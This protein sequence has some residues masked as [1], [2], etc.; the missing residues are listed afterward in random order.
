MTVVPVV[1]PITVLVLTPKASTA[2]IF[3]LNNVN[4]PVDEDATVG[5]AP[6][7]LN[8]V[9]LESVTVWFKIDAVP[10]A[11]TPRLNVEAAPNAVTLVGSPKIVMVP[12]LPVIIDALGNAIVAFLIAVVPVVEPIELLVAEA[13]TILVIAPPNAVKV[14]GSANNVSPAVFAVIEV[15]FGRASEAFLIAVVPVVPPIVLLV[16]D[17]NIILVIAPPKAVK[18][19]G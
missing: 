13:K 14:T 8:V 5:F 2:V 19:I 9:A 16:E 3:V 11:L 17:A 15:T 7:I 12:A 10:A 1:A 4:L 6:L 18:T